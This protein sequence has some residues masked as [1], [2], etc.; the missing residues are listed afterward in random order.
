MLHL[1]LILCCWYL[2]GC[3][4]LLIVDDEYDS[5][6]KWAVNSPFPLCLDIAILMWPYLIWLR[7]KW[8]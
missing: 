8:R 1:F 4:V 5:L 6:Y 7:I 2:I 3:L